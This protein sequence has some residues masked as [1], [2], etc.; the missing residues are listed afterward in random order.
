GSSARA[1]RA[2][3]TA[4]ARRGVTGADDRA[5]RDPCRY[6]SFSRLQRLLAHSAARNLTMAPTL[7]WLAGA[8]VSAFGRDG[9]VCR[10]ALWI[11]HALSARM[12]L[13]SGW[14]L[15]PPRRRSGHRRWPDRRPEE[16]ASPNPEHRDA[17]CSR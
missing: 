2:R 11:G 7:L 1:A 8:A 4:V 13:R 3:R 5:C 16:Q 15:V 9:E 6:P 12:P 14:V 10:L 17:E